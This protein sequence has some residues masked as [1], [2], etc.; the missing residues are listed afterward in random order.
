[1]VFKITII[2]TTYVTITSYYVKKPVKQKKKNSDGSSG[3]A[4]LYITQKSGVPDAEN[5][6][7]NF[8]PNNSYRLEKEKLE[9]YL[10]TI[11]FEYMLHIMPAENLEYTGDL[12]LNHWN[13]NWNQLDSMNNS[14]LNSN[15]DI[16]RHDASGDRLYIRTLGNAFDILRSI[17][18]PE[19]STLK[20]DKIDNHDG[21]YSY[22]FT[23]ILNDNL[24]VN[25]VNSN[26][27]NLGVPQ[28]KIGQNLILFGAPGTGKS[29]E[30]DKRFPNNDKYNNRIRVTFHPEYTYQDFVGS[31]LPEPLY[32]VESPLP[33]FTNSQNEE[34]EMGMPHVHYVFVPGP[35]TLILEKALN[36]LK[37]DDETTMFTIIIEEL[38]RANAP[39]VFGDLFQLL[40]REITGESRYSITNMEILNYLHKKNV[41]EDDQSELMLPPNLNIIATMNSADQGVF[42]MDSAFKRRW[43]FEYLPISFENVL[44]SQE[45]VEYGG[46]TVCWGDF[47]NSINKKL[48]GIDGVAE[49]KLIGPYFLKQNE[50]SN[51]DKIKDKLLMYLWEDVVKYE[52]DILFVNHSTFI[53]IQYRY[54]NGE[55]IFNIEFNYFES[56]SDQ[57]VNDELSISNEE[58]EEVEN[59][60]SDTDI[61]Y[62]EIDDDSESDDNNES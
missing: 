36:S 52:K 50:P 42:V 19:V 27:N 9:K 17:A 38:N 15:T 55:E 57:V 21:T 58:T 30:V 45:L 29:H 37:Y 41:L 2:D 5:F 26:Q 1:M 39:A 12:T 23:P 10:L 8:D 18:I 16:S 56:P 11:K 53:D 14:Q 3:G 49:D 13:Q 20:I 48:M 44:H 61:N 51:K 4:T 54:M 60:V 34:I 62:S 7:N 46:G 32:L 40:D 47:V 43:N 35:F 59:G 22:Q 28:E 33:K 31:F 24:S 6:F 25:T